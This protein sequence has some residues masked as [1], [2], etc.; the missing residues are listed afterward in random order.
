MHTTLTNLRTPPLARDWSRKTSG[1]VR[2]WKNAMS[3]CDRPRREGYSRIRRRSSPYRQRTCAIV[4]T[5]GL[6]FPAK[7][8]LE[9]SMLHGRRQ[10]L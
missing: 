8:S 5:A 6:A 9:A 10:Y 2:G 1:R 7:S 3:A 4:R